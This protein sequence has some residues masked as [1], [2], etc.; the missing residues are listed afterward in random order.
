MEAFGA[1]P[2][3]AEALGVEAFGA[4]PALAPEADRPA[5]S[6][7]EGRGDPDRGCDGRDVP[8]VRGAPAGRAVRS[9]PGVSDGRLTV[10]RGP[11]RSPGRSW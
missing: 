2:F 4:A 9:D 6:C 10:V 7:D 5:R 11:A 3:G 8:P 1:E